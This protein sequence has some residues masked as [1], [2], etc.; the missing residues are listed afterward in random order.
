V[1]A[2]VL[3]DT[4]PIVAYL[5]RGDA[6]HERAKR[7]FR[8]WRGELLTTW[9]VIT[10]AAYLS[11]SHRARLAIVQWIQRNLR[12][13]AQDAEDAAAI[14]RQLRKY[15]DLAPDLADLSLLVLAER[16]GVRDVVTIDTRDFAVFRVAGGRTLNNLLAR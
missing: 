6:W 14:E 13:V 12:V 10:E 2:S 3:V 15:A 5:H 11:E 1:P 8:R 9:P 7:F 16:S 4:G